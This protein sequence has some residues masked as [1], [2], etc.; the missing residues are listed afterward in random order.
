[1]RKIELALAAGMVLAMSAAI[2]NRAEAMAPAPA[3]ARTAVDAID[4]V[5]SVPCRLVWRCGHWGC[6]WRRICWRPHWGGYGGYG[7]YGGFGGGP[8]WGYRGGWGG[9]G[10]GWRRGYW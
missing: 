9:P 6:S 10:W 3:G 1:M 4:V 2:P 7:G 8:Y 5:E